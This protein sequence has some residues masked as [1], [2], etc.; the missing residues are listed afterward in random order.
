V[1][2]VLVGIGFSGFGVVGM[3]GSSGTGKLWVMMALSASASFLLLFLS[4]GVVFSGFGL[5][6]LL[7]G[8]MGVFPSSGATCGDFSA[9]ASAGC[10][11]I[12]GRVVSGADDSGILSILLFVFYICKCLFAAVGGKT[13]GFCVLIWNLLTEWISFFL[14]RYIGFGYS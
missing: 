6:R 2:V 14:I 9:P 4:R 12:V 5:S 11:G 8:G 7:V 13:Y 10:P 1:V 3:L